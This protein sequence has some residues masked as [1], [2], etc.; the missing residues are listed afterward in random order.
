MKKYVSPTSRKSDISP[1]GDVIEDLLNVYK[2]KG[3]INQT[4]VVTSWE[5]VMGK[6]ISSRTEEIYMNGGRL[7][8]KINSAPL[9]HELSMSKTKMIQM[10]NKEAGT[11]VVEDIVFL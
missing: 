10:L 3:K 11:A 9:K 8:V 7:F 1:L 5:K 6:T 4:S 2:L